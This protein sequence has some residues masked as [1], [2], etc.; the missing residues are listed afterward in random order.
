MG[1][2][3]NKF[4]C[5]E[6]SI[7]LDYSLYYDK[8]NEKVEER[9]RKLEGLIAQCEFNKYFNL[10]AGN[11]NNMY[12]TAAPS[13]SKKGGETSERHGYE[14]DMVC[15]VIKSVASFCI[16]KNVLTSVG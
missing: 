14:V 6:F 2:T 8:A 10:V 1:T 13:G 4:T 11:N 3:V 7:D 5:V 9:Y 12:F 15:S 16:I